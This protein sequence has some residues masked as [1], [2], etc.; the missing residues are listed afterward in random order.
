MAAG[1]LE[2]LKHGEILVGDGAFGTQLQARGMPPGACPEEYNASH[3]DIVQGIYLDYFKA[4]ADFVSTNSFGG[5]RVRLERHGM[6]ERATELAT[7]AVE[8]AR[9]VCPRDSMVAGSMGP[10]GE[11]LEP[12]G[13]FSTEEAYE[14]FAEQARV[15]AA[16]GVD[17]ILIETMMALDEALV[18]LRAA[19]T[20]TSVPVAVTMTFESRQKEFRTSWGVS[21][22]QAADAL[23]KAGANL[24]GSNCG[25]GFDNMVD[26]ARGF[27]AATSAPLIA[28]ANAGMPEW[29]DGKAVYKETPDTIEPKIRSLLE[30]GVNVIGGCCGTGPEHIARIRA[31]VNERR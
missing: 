25:Q 26:I 14:V 28:Q 11:L 1:L 7:R 9:H 19:K 13:A 6:G 29:V 5:N 27:R 30:A 23:T 4:G 16:A 3:P 15:L 10:T 8:L 24:V 12:F 2:R 17:F 31:I 18:A 22:P 20:N 21:I